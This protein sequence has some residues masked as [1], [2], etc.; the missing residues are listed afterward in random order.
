MKK[1]VL[2][3][4]IVH[5][6][7]FRGSSLGQPGRTYQDQVK[8]ERASWVGTVRGCVCCFFVSSMKAGLFLLNIV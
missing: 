6:I 7:N 5:L 2:Q 8:Y 1:G 4:S 3:T